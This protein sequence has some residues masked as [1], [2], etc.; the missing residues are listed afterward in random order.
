MKKKTIFEYAVI[1][2]KNR[3]TVETPDW[4]TEIVARD[5]IL[6]TDQADAQFQIFRA[7]D[8]KAV[9]KF[10]SENLVISIRPF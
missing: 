6:A 7:I 10:G 4:E 9:T 1:G 5:S 3:G 8:E 2:H